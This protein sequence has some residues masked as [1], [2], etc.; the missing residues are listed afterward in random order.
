MVPVTDVRLSKTG[1]GSAAVGNKFTYTLTVTNQ[2]PC[3]L[4]DVE[5][6]DQLPS[7]VQFV[8]G[9]NCTG[10]TASQTVQCDF[11]GLDAGQSEQ[12]TITV[13]ATAPGPAI[14]SAA[15]SKIEGAMDLVPANNNSGT[16]TVIT[17]EGESPPGD[18]NDG[19]DGNQPGGL[20]DDNFGTFDNFGNTGFARAST[21][22]GGVDTGAGG[23]AASS[24]AIPQ[25][26]L[27]SLLAI[28][29]LLLGLRRLGRA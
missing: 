18:G 16:A 20:N 1:P 22:L 15:I 24:A 2:G 27:A 5:V 28:G 3:D 10:S 11:G 25:I 23:T 14:N 13:E 19:N 21:P 7:N 29:F 9:T 4:T 12:G 6:T 17:P 8:S 26:S